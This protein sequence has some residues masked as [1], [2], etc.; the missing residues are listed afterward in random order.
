MRILQAIV[1]KLDSTN[2]KFYRP[3]EP[4]LQPREFYFLSILSVF[5]V[6]M[7]GNRGSLL[8]FHGHRGLC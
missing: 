4:Q 5:G 1:A 3:A 8:I 7:N 6:E 2:V